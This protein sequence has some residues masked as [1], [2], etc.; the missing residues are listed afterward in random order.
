M[1][2]H[3]P[4]IGP[5]TDWLRTALAWPELL[6][7]VAISLWLGRRRRLEALPWWLFSGGALCYAIARTWWTVDDT[8]IYHQ[9]V[10]FPMLPD[11]FFVLQY[12]FYFLAVILIPFGGFWGPRLLAIL[13]ALLWIMAATALSWYFLLAPLFAA[14]GLSPLARAVSLGYPVADLFLLLALMLILLRPLR[15]SEDLPVVG[16]VTAAVACLVVADTGAIF[17]ILHPAHVYQTGG[18]PDLFWLAADLLI[19]LAAL[20]QV[21]VVQRV[22]S[23]AR[24]AAEGQERQGL[25]HPHGPD[26]EDVRAAL[27]LFLPFLAALVASVAI[28]LR[29]AITATAGAG[30]HDMVAPL[31]VSSGLLLLVIVRQAVMFLETARLRHAMVA[32]QAEQ[33]ALRELD[34]RKDVF[35]SVVSHELRTPL[36]SLELFF[37]LLARRF[38][39]LPPRAAGAADHPDPRERGRE[40][41]PLHTALVYAHASV[42]RL[43]RLADDLVDDARIR[44]GRL[45]V[46]LGPCDLGTIVQ[47]AVEEQRAVEPDRTL[48]L[49]RPRGD[50]PVL[51]LADA[52]RI[53]QVVT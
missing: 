50:Q 24:P 34:R 40:A 53:G 12:P 11:L 13:D 45:S 1:L 6:I 41:E 32:T 31:A 8:L 46:H 19:P 18:V 27:R 52:E 25:Q 14:S 5:V 10:P 30:W 29:A 33:W 43:A 15:Y 37:A 17:L 26:A 42:R 38:A 49:E 44:H 48:L 36:A 16:L 28:L 23:A 4:W 7:M 2:R 22:Q 9:G 35:L 39:T 21:R 51:V 47:V 3:P 20:V